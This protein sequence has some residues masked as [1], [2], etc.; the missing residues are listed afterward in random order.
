MSH[1]HITPD[2]YRHMAEMAEKYKVPSVN[3]ELEC[4]ML[5][6]AVADWSDYVELEIPCFRSISHPS[7][8]IRKV[9]IADTSS[10]SSKRSLRQ[11]IETKELVSKI[12]DNHVSIVISIEKIY[13]SRFPDILIPQMVRHV[14][15]K[16]V[17]NYPLT[18]I[19][20][21]NGVFMLE[22]EY[23]TDTI[24]ECKR[25]ISSY[26]IPMWPCT[27][28]IDAYASE[29]ISA[30]LHRHYC[31][32]PKSDGEHVVIYADMHNRFFYITDNGQ[33]GGTRFDGDA[34]TIMEA[35]LIN[36]TFYIFDVMI[37]K[38]KDITTKPFKERMKNAKIIDNCSMHY[39]CGGV[40]YMHHSLGVRQGSFVLKE[41]HSFLDHAS[42]VK[43]FKKC[44]AFQ[45]SDGMIMTNLAGYD[46]K[47]YK[48]KPIPTVDMQYIDGYLYLAGERTSTRMPSGAHTFVNGAIYEFDM[49]M[50]LI[51]ERPDKIIPNYRMPVEV[52]PIT[53]IVSGYG[54]PN[55]RY[56]N[57]CVKSNLLR[58]LP[59]S[60]LLDIGSKYGGDIDK[61]AKFSKVYALDPELDLRSQPKNVVPLRCTISEMPEI[62]YDS[63][64]IFFVPWNDEFLSLAI[65]ANQVVMIIM[66]KVKDEKTD[67]YTVSK[68][69]KTITLD[70]PGTATAEHI[71]EKHVTK[72]Y[73]DNAMSKIG[74]E[75]TDVRYDMLFGTKDEIKLSRM[76][77]YLYYTRH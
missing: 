19:N 16:I 46:N 54:I 66:D 57:N 64:S 28:P 7:L 53:N 21:E 33:I 34:H 59:K 45:P 8:N 48:S 14:Q 4:R 9:E 74:F 11:I 35:E 61:W 20:Y 44:L 10:I 36:D 63:L 31:L 22:I 70:I 56:H 62:K 3:V 1:N 77:S 60:R 13:K 24:D 42:L 12:N 5:I 30:M 72:K 15:R 73:I 47:V 25:I 50:N 49:K 2:P 23:D 67:I 26:R 17:C 68:I 32:M 55:L 27:K 69:N 76:Y 52:D 58:I 71:V 43:A 6:P 18:V 37:S 39:T 65:K 51:R 75:S 29:F 40:C 38:G 41:Y